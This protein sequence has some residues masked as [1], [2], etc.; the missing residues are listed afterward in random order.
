ML[1]LGTPDPTQDDRAPDLLGALLAIA[2]CAPLAVRRA[3]PLAAAVVALPFA[4]A[5]L[6][7][8]Y[9]VIPAV[10]V[11]LVLCSRAAAPASTGDGPARRLRRAVIAAAESIAGEESPVPVRLLGGFAIGVRRC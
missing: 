6:A 5:A 2:A 9:L 4:G 1:R 11:G 3:Y 7:L 10:L 8:G